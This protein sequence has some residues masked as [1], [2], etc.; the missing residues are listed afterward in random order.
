MADLMPP[1]GANPLLL[2]PGMMLPPGM[3][4]QMIIQELQRQMAAGVGN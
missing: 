3:D 2:P 4:S 1:G